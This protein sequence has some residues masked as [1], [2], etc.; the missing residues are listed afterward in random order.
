MFAGLPVV[1]RRAE[2]PASFWIVIVDPVAL[3]R[4]VIIVDLDQPPPFDFGRPPPKLLSTG[5]A[6][7]L[8]SASA[9]P[10]PA[11]NRPSVL[12]VDDEADIVDLITAIL[13]DEGYRVLHA[14]DGEEAYDLAVAWHPDLVISDVTMPRMSGLQLVDRLRS[15]GEALARTPVILMSAVTRRLHDTRVAFLPKPFDLDDMLSMVSTELTAD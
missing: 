3:L 1:R 12:V 7:R 9:L 13:E 14:Y 2:R 6:H 5:Q 15:D 4:R 11:D 10:Q 8:G